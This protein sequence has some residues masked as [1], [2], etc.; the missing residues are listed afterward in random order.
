MYTHCTR[1][2]S[3][4]VVVIW[5]HVNNYPINTCS[6]QKLPGLS[7]SLWEF[8]Y[9]GDLILGVILLYMVYVSFSCFSQVAK[10]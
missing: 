9:M 5:L 4:A 8:I 2:I 3:S 10:S 1:S 6:V 7:I